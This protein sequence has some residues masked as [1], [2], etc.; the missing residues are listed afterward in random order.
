MRTACA[1][2]LL[3]LIA[4]AVPSPG[5]PQSLASAPERFFRIEAEGAQGRGGRPVVRGYVY[6][7]YGQPA[8]RMQLTAESL[9]ASGQVLGQSVIYVDTIVPPFSRAYFDARVGVAGTSYR[10]TVRYFEWLKGGGGASLSPPAPS[11]QAL[12]GAR[13][14]RS[15]EA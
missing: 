15:T 1:A 8:A 2:G 9:D 5:S 12:S 6:N 13:P 4:A 11:A 7:D 3:L 14:Y 10:L